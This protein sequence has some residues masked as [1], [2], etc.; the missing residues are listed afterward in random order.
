MNNNLIL[1]T[2][3]LIINK[4]SK[5]FK[6]DN[7]FWKLNYI[8]DFNDNFL[9]IKSKI[10][11]NEYKLFC[12][13]KKINNI[14]KL[15]YKIGEIYKNQKIEIIFKKIKL[16]PTYIGILINLK[17]LRVCHN[18]IKIIPKQIGNLVNLKSFD[19][20]HN[21]IKLIPKE[22]GNLINLKSFYIHNN[23]IKSL[24]KEI[25]NLISLQYFNMGNNQIKSV[26]KQLDNLINLIYFNIDN[27]QI[28][29]SD[30]IYYWTKL[31][32]KK[33]IFNLIN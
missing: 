12:Q 1:L 31:I 29:L 4:K 17:K 16:I 22:I 11:Y 2:Y 18:L 8:L 13:L 7:Y 26:P 33:L 10:F 32:L 20:D 15:K 3:L 19:M 21:Q 27:N 23:E 25:G 9:N 30:K 5:L 28:K 6:F 14:F 24:P